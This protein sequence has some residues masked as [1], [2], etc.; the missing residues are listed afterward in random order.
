MQLKVI[1]ARFGR[2]RQ[3]VQFENAEAVLELSFAVEEDGS[4]GDI[5]IE[6]IGMAEKLL[7]TV[8][9]L[10]LRELN[11]V[12]ADGNASVA[13][14]AQA[15]APAAEKKQTRKAAKDKDAE[16]GSVVEAKPNISTGEPRIDSAQTA[17][18]EVGSG[19]APVQATA[20][21][22]V[23]IPAGGAPVQATVVPPG[24]PTGPTAEELT[25]WVGELV[26]AG[27]IDS[28]TVKGISRKFGAEKIALIAVDKLT[29]YKAEVEE[30]VKRFSS[31]SDI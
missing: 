29:E 8:K 1:T 7:G 26:K 20:V 25:K 6:H 21:S 24:A 4:I 15:A 14:A 27:K 23:D 28:P 30:A 17:L 11:I 18:V 9:T 2:K 16:P 3:P 5:S 12:P 19:A 22:T 10:V 31:A 13:L